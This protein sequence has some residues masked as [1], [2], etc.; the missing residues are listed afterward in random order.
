VPMHSGIIGPA[1][2]TTDLRNKAAQR[3]VAPGRFRPSKTMRPGI[4]C[5]LSGDRIENS[6]DD[7]QSDTRFGN[8]LADGLGILSSPHRPLVRVR[9]VPDRPKFV[10]AHWSVSVTQGR[11]PWTWRRCSRGRPLFL[12]KGRPPTQNRPEARPQL[13]SRCVPVSLS[14]EPYRGR[15]WQR[16][17]IG[18]PRPAEAGTPTKKDQDRL[19]PELQ[20]K[21]TRTG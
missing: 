17:I 9:C 16:R 13:S 10:S 2:E 12:Q 11:R 4:T 19:K 3:R 15:L 8:R 18:S 14:W 20:R 1:P 5:A 6:L 21:K 7:R